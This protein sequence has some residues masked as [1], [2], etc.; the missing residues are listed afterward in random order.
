MES[1]DAFSDHLSQYSATLSSQLA[2][3][4]IGPQVAGSTGSPVHLMGQKIPPGT[5]A[6][7]RIFST[8]HLLWLSI[9]E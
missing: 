6:W 4:V 2:Q 8:W 3:F 7:L 5:Q 9:Q 1:A